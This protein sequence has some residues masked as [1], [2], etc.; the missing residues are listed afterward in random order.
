MSQDHAEEEI[1]QLFR[2]LK[3]EDERLAPPFSGDWDAALALRVQARPFRRASR[4]AFAACVALALVGGLALI[5]LRRPPA[6]PAPM[7]TSAPPAVQPRPPAAPSPPP[8][9]ASKADRGRG[10]RA[11][12][13]AGAWKEKSTAARHSPPTESQ[14]PYTLVSAWRSPT[15]FLLRPPDGRLLRTVP[16]LHGSPEKVKAAIFDQHN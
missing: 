8:L 1:R 2:K 15:D 9:L 5:L 10:A 11:G 16:R 6:R 3:E 4:P 14:P 7:A 12:W 13:K